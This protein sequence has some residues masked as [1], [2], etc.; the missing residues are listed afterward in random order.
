MIKADNFILRTLSEADI[1]QFHAKRADVY[2][3]G[4]YYPIN[5]TSIT[6]IRKRFAEDGY[7]GSDIGLLLIESN[8]GTLL[9]EIAFFKSMTYWSSYELSY[10]LYDAD[11]R[12]KGIITEATN[13]LVRYLFETKEV[14]RIQLCIHPD[15]PASNRVAQKCGFTHEGTARGAWF[16]RGKYESMEVYSIL[17]EDVIK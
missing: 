6:T 4:N 1:P 13:L 5:I 3:R 8:D 2:T 15:N 10:L 7:W 9:G 11:S 17:R 16:H 14:N 12:G